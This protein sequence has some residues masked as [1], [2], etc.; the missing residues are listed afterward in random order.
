MYFLYLAFLPTKKRHSP[1]Q[2]FNLF[3]LICQLQHL[4]PALKLLKKCVFSEV[5]CSV[6]HRPVLL[7]INKLYLKTIPQAHHIFWKRMKKKK[8]T[9]PQLSSPHLFL[10]YCRGLL[11]NHL[12]ESAKHFSSS[13]TLK[14]SKE[15]WNESHGEG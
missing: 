7:K 1:T 2:N 8:K 4:I 6:Q 13:A 15:D 10:S 14:T 12:H 11:F 3:V 5:C 9:N